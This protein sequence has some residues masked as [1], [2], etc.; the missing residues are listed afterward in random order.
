MEYLKEFL[1]GALV[2]GDLAAGLF[3]VRYW[4]VT[5]DRF[6]LFFAWSF[7]LGAVSRALLAAHIANSEAEPLIYSVR[8]LSYLVILLGIADINRSSIKKVLFQRT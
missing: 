5:G 6:F 2:M 8:L 7:A 3:F 4:K 1:L